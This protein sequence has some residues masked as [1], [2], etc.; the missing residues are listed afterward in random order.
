MSDPGRILRQAVALG[1]LALLIGAAVH[2]QLI[3][4]FARGEF[5]ESFFQASEYPGVRLITLEEGEDLWR[6]AQAAFIDARRKDL[7]DAGHLPGAR[8]VPASEA[9][10][11][12]PAGVLDLPRAGTL[13]VYCEGG[14]CQ[15]SL[16]LAKRLHDKGFKDIRVMTGGWEAWK[17]AGL[18]VDKTETT[19]NGET[20]DGQE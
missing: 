7:Y 4:R 16:L 17:T 13:V 11:A 1:G 2:F 5:R 18:P 19:G 10:K 6:T 14:D 15:S 20:G 12:L 3:K 9:E 8:S